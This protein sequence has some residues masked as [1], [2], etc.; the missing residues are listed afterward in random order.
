MMFCTVC[1]YASTSPPR[2]LGAG[3]AGT[4]DHS[5]YAGGHAHPR[6]PSVAPPSGLARPLGLAVAAR[7][8]AAVVAAV[9]TGATAPSTSPIRGRWCAGACP[10][11]S[12]VSTLAASATVGLLGLAA[13]LVPER[14]RTERRLT[15]VRHAATASVWAVAA[16]LEVVLTFA[17]LAGTPLTSPDLVGQLV[18]FTWSLETTRVLLVSALVAVV[19]AVCAR[20]TTRRAPMAW[21]AASTLGAVVVLALTGHAAG[22]ASHEDAV[23]ALAVHLLG[24]VVWTGGLLALVVMRR[25]SAR[26]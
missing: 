5:T 9:M 25:P 15:A 24:V 13:F 2:S 4:C 19:V 11:V 20:L 17:D 7:L 22:S 6:D 14:A 1:W 10:L 26:T 8:L 21:L 18:S 23:N 16:L 12:S 3:G